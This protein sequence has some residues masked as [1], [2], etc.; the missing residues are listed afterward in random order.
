MFAQGNGLPFEKVNTLMWYQMREQRQRCYIGT[1]YV[2]KQA[3]FD[4][5]SSELRLEP[6][7]IAC[8]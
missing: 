1:V 8:R 5:S 2:K 4:S 6:D 3:D 7:G